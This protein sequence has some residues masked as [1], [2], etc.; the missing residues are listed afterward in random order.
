VKECPPWPKESEHS[1]AGGADLER[2][3]GAS[4]LWLRLAG[5]NFQNGELTQSSEQLSIELRRAGSGQEDNDFV[6]TI[7][8]LDLGLRRTEKTSEQWGTGAKEGSKRSISGRKQ[9]QQQEH[10]ADD[11]RESKAERGQ[12]C[13]PQK[14]RT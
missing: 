7:A 13:L 10:C 3:H 9:T 5:V 12:I 14:N 8:A 4:T 1:F 11:F 2:V 6:D